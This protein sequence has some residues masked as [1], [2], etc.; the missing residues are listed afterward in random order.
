MKMRSLKFVIAALFLAFC[1]SG[2][3]AQSPDATPLPDDEQTKTEK[4]CRQIPLSEERTYLFRKLPKQKLPQALPYGR[5]PWYEKLFPFLAKKPPRSATVEEIEKEIGR[6]IP[7]GETKRSQ[8]IRLDSETKLLE[9]QKTAEQSW[10]NW[11][12]QNP[13]APREETEKAE[14]RI[15]FQGLSATRLERFDWR[16]QSL[17]VGEVDFQG[18]QCQSCWAFSA[19]DAMQISRRLVALR[20]GRTD[21]SEK[22]R[23]SVQQLISC[24]MPDDKDDYC[25]VGWHG[26]AFTFLVDKGLPLGGPTHYDERDYKTWTCDSETYVRALTWDFV[27][28]DPRKISTTDEIKRA[29][30]R[31][32][33]VVTMIH[34]DKCLWL[35]GGGT[36]NGENNGTG[37]HF[38]TIIGWDDKKGAW[39]VKNSFGMEW[40]EFGFGWIKYGSNRIGESSAWIMADPKEEERIAREF[41]AKEEK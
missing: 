8:K 31:Y 30:I 17:D 16:E 37:S 26:E 15:R 24:M 33:P 13:N 14:I 10:Q 23:P 7:F 36:F 27:S 39:L 35:Y 34:F 21:F 25:K 29:L 12:Q 41:A 1:G 9:M 5:K 2:I 3:E 19:V 11:L 32:G 18:F 40:G 20:M 4:A 6:P 38:V 22:P 28:E